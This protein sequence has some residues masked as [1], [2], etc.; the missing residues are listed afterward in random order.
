MVLLIEWNSPNRGW[1]EKIQSG[2]IWSLYSGSFNVHQGCSQQIVE[3]LWRPLSDFKLPL[4]WRFRLKKFPWSWRFKL[5]SR[6]IS[7]FCG[8]LLRIWGF[9]SLSGS[10]H[11]VVVKKKNK[12][13]EKRR[14]NPVQE[15][16]NKQNS[17]I[18]TCWL[19]CSHTA[20][21]RC[22]CVCKSLLEVRSLQVLSQVS[23]KSHTSLI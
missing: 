17:F 22:P 4:S 9:L 23:H 11:Q 6:W 16:R 2:V 1:A 15:T 3:N 18:E 20:S 7:V 19:I 10:R 21:L 14:E 12:W 13:D 5:N 8:K